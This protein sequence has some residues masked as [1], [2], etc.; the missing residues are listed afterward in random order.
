MKKYFGKTISDEGVAVLEPFVGTG[1]FITRL[2]RSGLIRPEDLERKYKHEI[3]AN[4]IVL[5]SYYIASINIESVYEEISGEVFG[6]R[7]YIPFEGISLTDTFQLREQENQFDDPIFPENSERLRRQKEADIRV[8]VMN[9]PYS[10]G[11]KSAND[12]NANLAYPKLEGSRPEVVFLLSGLG[13][14]LAGKSGWF[15]LGSKW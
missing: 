10:S 11:Q 1:T 3:F 14:Y 13:W 8:I 12:N 7:T 5:L 9:P 15:C 6:E 2:L 4:E